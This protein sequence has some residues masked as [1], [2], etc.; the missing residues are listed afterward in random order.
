MHRFILPLA[1][2]FISVCSFRQ[3]ANA[4]ILYK[5]NFHDKNYAKYEGLIVYFNESRSYMRVNYY[6][7]GNK[8]N[9]VNV[10]YT[11]STGSYNDGGSYFFMKGSNAKYITQAT[12]DM[13]YNPDHFI[14]RKSRGQS[15]WNMPSTTDDPQLNIVNE[16]PVDSFYQVN[17]YNVTEA[18]LRKFFW[19]NEPDFFAL[20][21]LCGLS[22]TTTVTPVNTG[23]SLHLIVVANTLIGDIGAG[24]AADRDKL[25]YEFKGI[26]D[27]LGFGYKKYIVDG[28]N[29]N[30]ASVQTTLASVSPGKNDIVIFVYRGHGFRWDNQKD[31]Y[32]MMDLRT[33][34]YVQIAQTT[35]LGLS[36]VY[37]TLSAKGARLNIVLADCC[38][39]T[40]GI[41]QTTTASFL[42]SQ[43][44]NK[45][46]VVKLKKLFVNAHGNMI[47]AAA[48]SG[49]YSWSNPFGGFFT[50]SFIQ[51][52]KDRISYLDN[53]N[54]AWSDV[55]DYTLKLAKDKSS[56]ALCSNCTLQTGVFYVNVSY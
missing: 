13:Q 49:E 25:D 41:N 8:Y 4:Q 43:S 55:I 34:S 1:I 40:V 23:A 2:L 10:D 21:Q 52:M 3:Q 53:G 42:N 20:K 50:L 9:V 17:P 32:P 39:N 46:D 48:H 35:S 27:A 54:A 29:F 51:A 36:D 28:S 33:S 6:S 31:A 16:V 11:S 30:K 44:D 15:S 38:N 56:P 37:N 7:E 5:V 19:D 22:G 47:T 26:A 12:A 18:F 14:W 45:P 24:C